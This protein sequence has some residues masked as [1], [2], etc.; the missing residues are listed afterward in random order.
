MTAD[1]L[2]ALDLVFWQKID[3][4]IFRFCL[5]LIFKRVSKLSI[6]HLLIKRSDF[7]DVFSRCND[8]F[9]ILLNLFV[10]N[11]SESLKFL[12]QDTIKTKKLIQRWTQSVHF[13]LNK[14]TISILKKEQLFL[15]KLVFLV[16]N[17]TCTQSSS[18]RAMLEIF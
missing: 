15:Q 14:D 5:V 11:A 4:F 2:N 18:M 13:F 3:L 1:I 10:K 8:V 7:C 16:N 6:F 17:S 12:L 9:V